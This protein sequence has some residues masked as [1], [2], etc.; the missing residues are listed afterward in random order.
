MRKKWWLIGYQSK[1]KMSENHDTKKFSENSESFDEE[2]NFGMQNRKDRMLVDKVNLADDKE[3]KN[4]TKVAV[5]IF[6]RIFSYLTF[7]VAA[8]ISLGFTGVI[9]YRL[10]TVPY[11][12]PCSIA[13]WIGLTTFIIGVWVPSPSTLLKK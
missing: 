10:V 8:M 7:L 12:D 11:D 2:M 4:Y 6:A 13:P 3:V 5:N 1:L 9:M